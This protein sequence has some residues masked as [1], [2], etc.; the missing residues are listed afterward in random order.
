MCFF[1]IFYLHSTYLPF[2]PIMDTYYT[3]PNKGSECDIILV[4]LH[5]MR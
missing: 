4:T 3:Q 1:F 2:S 5:K